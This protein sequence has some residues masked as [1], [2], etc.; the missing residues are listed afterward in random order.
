MYQLSWHS[1]FKN[2]FK[3]TTKNNL[4]LKQKIINT[5]E[6]LQED[7]FNPKLNTHKLHGKLKGYWASIVEYDCRIVFTFATIPESKNKIIVLIDIGTH[8]EVY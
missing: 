5:L 3:K 2:A 8:N 4:E 1:S 7:P 6:L